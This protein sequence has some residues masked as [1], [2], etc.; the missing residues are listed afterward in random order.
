MVRVYW[1][2]GSGRGTE[3][4]GAGGVKR[5]CGKWV[6]LPDSVR[7]ISSD[8]KAFNGAVT[9]RFE[10]KQE[11]VIQGCGGLRGGAARPVDLRLCGR[12][13]T[14]CIDGRSFCFSGN[15]LLG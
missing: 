5:V 2:A 1:M 13:C 11:E 12:D 14:M 3:A 7:G 6:P 4:R 9:D 8:A 15:K 10:R